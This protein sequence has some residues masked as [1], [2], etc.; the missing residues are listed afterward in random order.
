MEYTL[1]G[2]EW[3]EE[4]RRSGSIFADVER[5]LVV[6]HGLDAGTGV[7]LI[8]ENERAREGLERERE[9]E[10]WMESRWIPGSVLV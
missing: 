8:D 5:F 4:I 1:V 7:N 2:M 10:I 9:K 6:G 3:M